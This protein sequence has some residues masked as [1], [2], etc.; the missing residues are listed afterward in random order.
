L[1]GTPIAMPTAASGS[2]FP[3][4]ITGGASGTNGITEGSL[5][6]S[7]DGRYL[8]L[9]G[10]GVVPGTTNPATASAATAPR[11]IARI[12]ASGNINTTTRLLTAFNSS[13]IRT[14]VTADGTAFWASGISGNTTG[15]AWYQTLGVTTAG[16]QLFTNPNNNHFLGIFGGQLYGDTNTSVAPSYYSVFTIGTG[17]P[18]TTGQTVSTLPGLPTTPGTVAPDPWDF[19]LLDRS[20]TIAGFD[21]LYIADNRAIASGGGIQRWTYNG[22]TWSL[23]ATFSNI[24]TPRPFINLMAIESASNVTLIAVTVESTTTN[25]NRIVMFVDDGTATS[26]LAGTVISTAGTNMSYRGVALTP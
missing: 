8:T 18:T 2:N 4:T 22:T 9:A 15:G 21:T 5:R 7:V 16:I 26:T 3:F 14:A 20:P 19:V 11:V 23:S 10:Y 13:N 24:P 1:V 17:L 12:D 6:R 25:P